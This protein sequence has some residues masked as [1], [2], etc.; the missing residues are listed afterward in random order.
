MTT[1]LGRKPESESGGGRFAVSSTAKEK[2]ARP[3]Q[4]ALAWILAQKPSMVPIP[5]TTKLHRLKENIASVNIERSP[6]DLRKINEAA[7]KIDIRGARYPESA[8]KMINR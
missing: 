5:G 7:S 6:E 3:A 8:Q 2:E 4:I 1:F